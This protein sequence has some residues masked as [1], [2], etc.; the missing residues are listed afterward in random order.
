M[1]YLGIDSGTQSTKSIVLDLESGEMLATAQK[2]YGLVPDLPT[3]HMEQEPQEWI[4]ATEETILE[5]LQKT[6]SRKSELRAIGVSGQQHGLVVLND[7]NEV[8]RAAKLWNDTSTTQQCTE[9]IEEFGGDSALIKLMGNTMLPGWTAPK[10]LWLRQNE[11]ENYESVNSILLPH[12]YINLWL[13]G[14]KRMEYGD[15]S[16][17]GLL[18]VRTRRWCEAV[19]EFID[20]ELPEK[21]PSLGPSRQAVGLLRE[22]LRESWG[23]TNSPIVS[24]G[25]G[26]NMMGAIGTGN[27]QS[28]VVTAS[29]GTSGTIY[30]F[31]A[32]PV[33]DPQGEVAA[34][35][36]STDN[37]LPLICTMNV[38]VATEQVRRLFG[39][40]LAQLDQSVAGVAP[41]SDGLIF[42]PYLTGERTPNL[43]NGVGV[44]HGLTLANLTPPHLA[45]AAMEG[46]TLGL[47]YGLNRFRQLGIKPNEIRLTG[48]GSRSAVWRQICAD[49]FRVPVVCL[50]TAEGAAL[51]AALHSAWVDHLVNNKSSNLNELVAR[52]VKLDEKSRTLPGDAAADHYQEVFGRF[53]GLTQR[54]ATGGYL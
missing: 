24:A 47:A 52:N 2:S 27:V 53:K 42:L 51:G 6:G 38:T 12:D 33:V 36:D 11:P 4:D 18:D 14:E 15:A 35:C 26:D 48:G 3:G 40:E 28:G 22:N 21:L 43:P 37:W 8:V 34:F 49:V 5:C 7:A 39:W 50:A 10:I 17:T 31:S 20:P 46:A 1:L 30:A 41:G 9:I 45:R 44:F 19:L 16:G 13:T 54:L 29:L 32:Q 25:G 23:L